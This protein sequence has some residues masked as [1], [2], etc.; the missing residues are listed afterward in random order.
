MARIRTIKPEFFRH[1]G[2]QDLEVAN[3][4]KYPM[5]VFAGLWGHCDKDGRFEWRPRQLK[6]DILPFLPFDM[7][8]VLALLE[9][10]GFVESYEVDGKKYG[11]IHSFKEHQRLSGK[12][13]QEGGKH[14]EPNINNDRS[15]REAPGKHQGSNGEQP[16][17]QEGKGREGNGVKGREGEEEG[18]GTATSPAAP[19]T[20]A[21][22]S[23]LPNDWKLPK[24]WGEWAQK[25]RPAWT[26][27]Q[28]RQVA[29]KFRDHWIGIGGQK[30]TKLDWEATWRNWVRNE[31]DQK[32]QVVQMQPSASPT[33]CVCCGKVATYSVGGKSYC[34]EHDQYSVIE[35]AA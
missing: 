5:M 4:G 13:S 6:L 11:V 20:T 23:R 18:S 17:S 3:P 32:G 22:A 35:A 8:D 9:S 10:A 28:I 2:L 1:E 29:D 16:E 7:A 25:E 21:K 26:A 24:A 19:A 15:N 27:D 34:R 31:G 30:G 14:P 33:V 12:E